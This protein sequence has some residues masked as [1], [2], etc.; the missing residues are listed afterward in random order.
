MRIGA[1]EAGGTKFVCGIG[2]ENG[3]IEDS[4]RFPTEAPEITM[5]RVIDYFR[6]EG[7]EAIGIGSFGPMDLD[8]NRPK[9][10]YV[11]TTPKPGWSDYDFIGALREEFDV[12]Y[13][14]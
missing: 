8:R 10:G 5:P 4:V 13:G 14:W 12:P 6:D 7:V 1:I 11:T 2:N 3:Q 9:Y